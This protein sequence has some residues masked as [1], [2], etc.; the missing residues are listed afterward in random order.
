MNLYKIGAGWALVIAVFACDARGAPVAPNPAPVR[1]APGTAR[2][3][4]EA[5]ALGLQESERT[6]ERAREEA[7]RGAGLYRDSASGLVMQYGVSPSAQSQA[8]SVAWCAN[9][10]FAGGGWR[11]PTKDE[12]LMVYD[13]RAQLEATEE[14]F[15]SSSNLPDSPADGWYVE[16][17]AVG[18]I[19]Y[20]PPT[21]NFFARCVREGGREGGKLGH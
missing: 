8:D 15:W 21:Q 19:F 18:G 2:E 7:I 9:L 10:P 17:D 1:A 12:L 20:G 16:F 14:R 11:L 5:D 13:N 3:A 4:Q 6:D